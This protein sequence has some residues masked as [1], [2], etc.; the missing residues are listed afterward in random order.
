[1]IIKLIINL[2]NYFCY[3]IQLK[4]EEVEYI[5]EKELANQP[6]AIPIEVM[7]KLG[8]LTR[9]HICKINSNGKKELAFF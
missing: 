6:K 7:V 9:T 8:D 4:M 2:I 1:M 5:E 3:I